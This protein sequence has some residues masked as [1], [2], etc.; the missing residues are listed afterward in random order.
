MILDQHEKH[1]SKW[2]HIANE[3]GTGFVHVG[4]SLTP[5][6]LLMLTFFVRAVERAF[7]FRLDICN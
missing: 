2:Q 7:M 6:C 4:Y 1:G 3:L 5:A